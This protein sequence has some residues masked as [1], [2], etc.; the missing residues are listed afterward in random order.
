MR[1]KLLTLFFFAFITLTNAQEHK[2][3]TYFTNDSTKLELDLFLPKKQGK[4]KLP[5]L[6]H[7]HGGGFAGGERIWGHT[8]AKH[9]ASQGYAAASISYTLYM[10]DKNFSCNGI[11]SEKIKAIQIAV[12]QLWQATLF[13]NNNSEKYNI[14]TNKIFISGSSA[15]A[16][17]ALHA[18]FWDRKIMTIYPETLPEDFQYAGVISGA[19]AIMDLNLITK[20]NL[21]P[22][23][24]FHGSC[25]TTVPYATA[26]H[27]FC[28]ANSSGWL[29]LFGSLSIFEHIEKLNGSCHLTTYCG[30]GHEYSDELF[31]KNPQSVVDFMNRT[32]Q[33][34][35]ELTHI[36]VRGKDCKTGTFDF[37][38]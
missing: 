14:D 32:L 17:T 16:E 9:A 35:K 10:K 24:L 23:Q 38:N 26:A 11:L 6:I 18:A 20:K 36:I 30:G 28:P 13:F 25:D 27:H 29:M 21:I 31:A 1:L 37:C 3:I 12:N 34:K 7:V 22:V 8:I 19:G 15:G 4:E 33:N 5:L 2:T